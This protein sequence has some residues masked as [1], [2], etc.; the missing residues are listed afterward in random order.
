M[1]SRVLS[2]GALLIVVV[3]AI[4]FQVRSVSDFGILE[5]NA[6]RRT[7]TFWMGWP[8]TYFYWTVEERSVF[9][10]ESWWAEERPTAHLE[11]HTNIDLANINYRNLLIVVAWWMAVAGSVWATLPLLWLRWDLKSLLLLQA[12]IAVLVLLR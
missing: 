10:G 5:A 8:R 4:V 9:D 3:I 2:I 11:R 1:N 7:Q 12:S 6:R